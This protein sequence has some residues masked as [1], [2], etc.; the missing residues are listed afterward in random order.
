MIVCVMSQIQP[1]ETIVV[2][3]GEEDISQSNVRLEVG[4]GSCYN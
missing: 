3:M 4:I 1:L 2:R